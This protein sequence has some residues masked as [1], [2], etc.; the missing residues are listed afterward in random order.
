LAGRRP[1]GGFLLSVVGEFAWGKSTLRNAL[2]IASEPA[3]RG[4]VGRSA[5]E[6]T[7]RFG[8]LDAAPDVEP[9]AEFTR[10]V[11]AVDAAVARWAP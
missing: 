6:V 7:A 10:R 1:A 11:V 2:V 9:A 5:E 8:S 4:E 3:G